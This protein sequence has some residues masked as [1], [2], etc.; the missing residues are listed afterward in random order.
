MRSNAVTSCVSD[1][2]VFRLKLTP[3]HSM[4]GKRALIFKSLA[5]FAI[6][7]CAKV[8]LYDICPPHAEYFTIRRAICQ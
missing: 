7:E 2:G 6:N 8:Y 5:N 1:A 3:G 4:S